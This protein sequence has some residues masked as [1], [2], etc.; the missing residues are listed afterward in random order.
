MSDNLKGILAM[1]ASAAGFVTNDAT[2]KFVTQELP[3]GEIIFLRGLVATALMGLVTSIMGGW[4]SPTVLFKPAMSLRLVAAA[5]ATLFIVAALRHMPLATTNAILQVSPL[6][7]TAGAAILLGAHVGWRRWTASL[8][9]FAGVLLIVKPG[10]DG[11]VPEA[12]LVLAALFGSATRDLTTRFVD[13]SIPSIFVT[14]ATSA[15]IT[16]VGLGMMPF[17]TWIMPSPQALWLILLASVCL[18]V[19]YHFGVVAMRTGEIPVVAPFRY[20]SVVLALIL[21]FAIWGYMPDAVSLT[22]IALIVVA[23]LF[24][25]YLERTAALRRA[26]ASRPLTPLGKAKVAS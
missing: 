18:F 26:E 7:V 16:L 11:F 8:L 6:L 25:L 4:R 23:G 24:L 20:T 19:A 13:H 14:F 3:N 5:F 2:V 22:G 10:M 9:G 17:E 21:G 1:L 15:M 12:L